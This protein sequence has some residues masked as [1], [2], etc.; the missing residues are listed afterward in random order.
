VER[1]GSNCTDVYEVLYLSILRDS[2]KQIQVTLKLKILTALFMK[3]SHGIN[4]KVGT[5]S[6]KIV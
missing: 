1:I 2:V 6:G 3:I 5:V 4:L